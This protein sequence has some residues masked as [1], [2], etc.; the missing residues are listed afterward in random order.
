[1][2][3]VGVEGVVETVTW[4]K[5]GGREGAWVGVG[6]ILPPPPLKKKKRKKRDAKST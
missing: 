6:G 4:P 5:I 3:R 2:Y 1:M